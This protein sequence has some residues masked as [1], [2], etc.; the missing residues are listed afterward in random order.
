MH[1]LY[2]ALILPELLE[3]LAKRLFSPPALLANAHL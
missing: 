2:I 1:F 3:T